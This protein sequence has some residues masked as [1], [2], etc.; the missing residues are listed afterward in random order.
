MNSQAVGLRVSSVI[1]G[2]V[3]LAHVFRLW[4]KWEINV[5]GHQFGNIPSLFAVV[6]SALLSVWLWTLST[7]KTSVDESKV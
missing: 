7:C 4:A 5:G 1:F 3:C 2:F 6:V